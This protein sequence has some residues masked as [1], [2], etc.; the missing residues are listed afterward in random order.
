[1]KI[2]QAAAS[3][4]DAD[5]LVLKDDQILRM[6]IKSG[7]RRSGDKG[8]SFPKSKGDGCDVLAIVITNEGGAIEYRP[9]LLVADE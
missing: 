4:Y 6:K 1:M 7:R 9:P 3:G 2:Y 8:L 5:L